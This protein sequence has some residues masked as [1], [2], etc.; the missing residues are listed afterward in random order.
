MLLYML[1]MC[2]FVPAVKEGEEEEED[3]E[4]FARFDLH[5]LQF[6]H[7]SSPAPRAHRVA[8]SET[9]RVQTS[10]VGEG[11]QSASRGEGTV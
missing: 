6:R 2:C 8:T 5:P 3:E 9:R 11:N 10:S 7:G 1:T 4:D